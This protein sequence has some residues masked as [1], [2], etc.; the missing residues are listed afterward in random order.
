MRRTI[1]L[2]SKVTT[3]SLEL[4]K[5]HPP[6]EIVKPT[7]A[8]PASV[9]YNSNLQIGFR[10]RVEGD[11]NAHDYPLSILPKNVS[12]RVPGHVYVYASGANRKQRIDTTLLE[13]LKNKVSVV[14]L[15]DPSAL[16]DAATVE[17]S[18]KWIEEISSRCGELIKSRNPE[19]VPSY[20]QT[21]KTNKT[22]EYMPET[23]SAHE[24]QFLKVALPTGGLMFH[25]IETLSGG[26]HRTSIFLDV[27][28]QMNFLRKN[29]DARRRLFVDDSKH[30]LTILLVDDEGFIRWHARGKPAN[31]ALSILENGIKRLRRKGGE[32]MIASG[33][34]QV[35]I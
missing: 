35:H 28:F 25:M 13:V 29:D 30:R 22:M 1:G 33:R 4:L 21:Q 27:D 31:E 15:F 8:A 11:D 12:E 16:S 5:F 7:S 17:F 9:V 18:R 24:V 32:N 10:P 6:K 14:F 20:F 3:S 26:M 34:P 19:A 2:F 23:K